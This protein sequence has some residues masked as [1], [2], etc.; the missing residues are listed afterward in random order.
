MIEINIIGGMTV[1][2]FS[3]MALLTWLMRKGASG[4]ALTIM[5]VL[6]AVL[7]ILFYATGRP[8]GIDPLTATILL[9][10]G[11]LPAFLGGGAG[12]LLGWMLRR[13]DDRQI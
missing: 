3:A 1:L 10:V 8:I 2:A 9:F 12:A 5:S 4:L 11:V 7:V 13:R 6:G